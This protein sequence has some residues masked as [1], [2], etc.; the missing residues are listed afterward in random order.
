MKV[1]DGKEGWRFLCNDTNDV[2]SQ[3]QG[4]MPLSYEEIQ[5]WRATINA[6]KEFAEKLGARYYYLIVPNKHC[7]YKEKLPDNLTVSDA[8]AAVQ[9]A[10]AFRDSIIYP[11]EYL[12]LQ[13]EQPIYRKD[14]THWNMLGLIKCMNHIGAPLG[15][16]PLQYKLDGW[17]NV[18][19]G[20]L[21]DETH[22]TMVGS[23][24][25][26]SFSI[27]QR[28]VYGNNI[29]NIG[30]MQFYRHD[31]NHLPRAVIFG[32][33]FFSIYSSILAEYFSE[34]YY[35]HAPVYDLSIIDKVRPDIIISENVE[36]FIKTPNQLTFKEIF[37]H[38]IFENFL[39]PPF[40][41]QI[42]SSYSEE[43][44]G[45]DYNFIQEVINIWRNNS[46]IFL[47]KRARLQLFLAHNIRF[48]YPQQMLYKVNEYW[49]PKAGALFNGWAGTFIS[50]DQ[51]S[52]TI[53][54]IPLCQITE[55]IFIQF[56][57]YPV[58]DSLHDI[59][60]IISSSPLYS[61][62]Y[63]LADIS[64]M[65]DT[66]EISFPLIASCMNKNALYI[67][68]I[69]ASHAIGAA[70]IR[71]EAKD[72]IFESYYT[73]DGTHFLPITPGYTFAYKFI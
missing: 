45:I 6:R 2:I 8:R 49:V 53:L 56:H 55:N 59:N 66:Q 65:Q 36:R 46:P 34:L 15:F 40:I 7:V 24:P 11:L 63:S 69:I 27:H 68:T 14:D 47:L 25:K 12:R 3:I 20:D 41:E 1:L 4:L 31:N 67:F 13:N 19:D 32:Y 28:R 9:L 26:V 43:V 50:T 10:Q 22:P 51:E 48:Q 38:K 37:Y 17:K 16:E 72:D 29:I 60:T 64:Q 44:S 61:Y 70:R 42:K 39:Y 71:L 33:S 62:S 57:I 35:F 52:K 21:V 58:T 73:T 30:R 23:V 54:K 18:T 5:L